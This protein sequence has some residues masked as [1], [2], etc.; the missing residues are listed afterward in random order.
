MNNRLRFE[1]RTTQFNF[2]TGY[3][4]RDRMKSVWRG[5]NDHYKEKINIENSDVPIL[6]PQKSKR[7]RATNKYIEFTPTDVNLDIAQ[8]TGDI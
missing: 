8:S 7:Y 2:E 4:S 1:I 5:N 3:L 6:S